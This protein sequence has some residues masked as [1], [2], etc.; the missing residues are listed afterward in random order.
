[1]REGAAWVGGREG[2]FGH[3]LVKLKGGLGG[4]GRREGGLAV[5]GFGQALKPLKPETPHCRVRGEVVVG[6]H[7]KT[8]RA[9][10]WTGLEV[11]G[12]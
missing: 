11:V 8:N 4:W 12:G 5:R 3:A 1:M 2:G 10:R 9:G 7:T 6:A